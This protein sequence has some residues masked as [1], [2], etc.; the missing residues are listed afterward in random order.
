MQQFEDNEVNIS[1]FVIKSSDSSKDLFWLNN[2]KMKKINVLTEENEIDFVYLSNMT[3]LTVIN[4][5]IKAVTN[6][7]IEFKSMQ[8][9][10]NVSI[11]GIKHNLITNSVIKLLNSS[12]ISEMEVNIDSNEIG[13]DM[14]YLTKGIL[15][16]ANVNI[17]MNSISSIMFEFDTTFANLS[18]IDI[19]NNNVTNAGFRLKTTQ[20]M[21]DIGSIDSNNFG[22]ERS[23]NVLDLDNVYLSLEIVN[24]TFNK[25]GSN[26]LN[27]QL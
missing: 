8:N 14:I 3:N 16:Y 22:M 25:V 10:A 12:M 6:D 19:I 4:N 26:T 27:H 15:S 5:T 17:E 24:I 13:N 18:N 11:L 1:T 20:I 9:I 7:M 21:I 2:V 23:N